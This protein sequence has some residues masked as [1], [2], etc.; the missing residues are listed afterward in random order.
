[1]RNLLDIIK[2]FILSIFYGIRLHILPILVALII[3]LFTFFVGIV[4]V[5][6]ISTNSKSTTDESIQTPQSTTNQSSTRKDTYTS[7]E[8]TSTENK[9][10]STTTTQSK[11]STSITEEI[12]NTFEEAFTSIVSITENFESTVSNTFEN[13][14]SFIYTNMITSISKVAQVDSEELKILIYFIIEGELESYQSWKVEILN[15]AMLDEWLD[16]STM[17]RPNE[18]ITR[19]EFVKIMNKALGYT[20][21]AKINYTDVSKDKWYYEDIQIAEHEGYIDGYGDNT[22]KPEQT[23]TREEV[24][25]II[26][27]IKNNKKE[28]LEK[29][30]EYKDYL[31]I[32]T[33]AKSAVEGA[34]A[35]EYMAVDEEKFRP[36]DNMTI[37]E[38][39]DML[40]RFLG[41]YSSGKLT[42]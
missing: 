27:S 11:S 36:K 19:A 4:I 25:D 20:K 42:V 15:Q 8:K 34:T 5:I 29:I 40:Q 41:Y 9:T 31:S 39:I 32:A 28:N 24:A 6:S 23:I 38:T 16:E 18:S 33:W 3:I 17:F 37:E 22:F 21:K 7:E 35:N 26:T 14:M 2:D 13:T 10:Q 12:K 30:Y 1:M